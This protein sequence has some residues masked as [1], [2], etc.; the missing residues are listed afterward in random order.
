MRRAT[1]ITERMVQLMA[2]AISSLAREGT[3]VGTRSAAMMAD[4]SVYWDHTAG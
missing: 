1:K 4:F 3:P 2:V